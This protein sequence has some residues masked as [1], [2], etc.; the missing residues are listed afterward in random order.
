MH[1]K[2]NMQTWLYLMCVCCSVKCSTFREGK[3]WIVAKPKNTKNEKTMR[4]RPQHGLADPCTQDCY[5]YNVMCW[6]HQSGDRPRTTSPSSWWWQGL[7]GCE[8]LGVQFLFASLRILAHQ[9]NC[10]TLPHLQLSNKIWQQGTYVYF[11]IAVAKRPKLHSCV[12]YV[13]LSQTSGCLTPAFF[14][15]QISLSATKHRLRSF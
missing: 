1:G 3:S 13:S 14:C 2:T 8:E 4:T 9:Q 7:F 12:P 10:L 6:L 15:T 5:G 11:F